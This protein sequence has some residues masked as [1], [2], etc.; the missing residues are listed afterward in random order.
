MSVNYLGPEG[1][2][3]TF[4]LTIFFFWGGGGGGRGGDLSDFSDFFFF[5]AGAGAGWEDGTSGDLNIVRISKLRDILSKGPKY[6]EPRPFVN[7]E[8]EFQIN[9][10]FC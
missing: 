9:F 4:K 3:C 1:R 8:I 5:L 2:G 7:L 10:G 6:R